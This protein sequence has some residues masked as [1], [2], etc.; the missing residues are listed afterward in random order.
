[1]LRHATAAEPVAQERGQP[2]PD[3][4]ALGDLCNQYRE[5]VAAMRDAEAFSPSSTNPSR[6]RAGGFA[7]GSLNTKSTIVWRPSGLTYGFL[8]PRGLASSSA[9]RRHTSASPRKRS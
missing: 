3:A 2:L 8:P 7:S 9:P 1:M 4:A 5:R 6:H